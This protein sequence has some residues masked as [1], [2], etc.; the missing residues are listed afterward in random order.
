MAS[1]LENALFYLKCFFYQGNIN[2]NN[3]QGTGFAWLVRPLLRKRG[4]ELTRKETAD[5]RGYFNTNPSFITLVL[6]IFL[7]AL[8]QQ[9]DT[10]FSVRNSYA[11]ACAGLGDSFFWHGL[12][13]FLFIL[14]FFLYV[15]VSEYG[16]LIYPLVYTIFHLAFILVGRR[17]GEA[18]GGRT[19]EIFN[20]FKLKQWADFTDKISVILVGMILV[21]FIKYGEQG[22]VYWLP[23]AFLV[24]ILG[25]AA[26]KCLRPILFLL[27]IIT[28][29]LIS[30]YL[31]GT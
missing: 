29:I 2:I 22:T 26:H 3:M 27:T 7:K 5:L 16:A 15:H 30:G 20:R 25:F 21:N 17:I 1:L 10:A 19:V 12:R 31:I 18:L 23:I 14:A 24:F 4:I 11:S 8:T 28:F 13:P 9:R 6:G